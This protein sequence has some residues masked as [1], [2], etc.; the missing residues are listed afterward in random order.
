MQIRPLEISD[1]KAAKAFT[2]A[3]IGANYYSESEWEEIFRKSMKD[4]RQCTLVLADDSSLIRGVRITYP[5]GNWQKG[6]GKGLHP[7]KWGVA[8]EHV[9]YFQSIFLDPQ[10]TGGGWG[11]KMSLRA[12]EILREL[13]AHAIV[14]HSWKESPNDSSGRYL[15]SLGFEMV[16]THPLYWHDVDYHCAGCGKKPCVCTAEEM[17][18]KLG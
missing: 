3:T 14:T 1:L 17:I 2:D 6:K 10:I 13:K 4:G 11:R 5:P 15:R 9:A 7:E 16:A 8:L 18:L 12:I